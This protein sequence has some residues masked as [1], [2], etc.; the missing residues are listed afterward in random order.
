MPR[1]KKAATQRKTRKREVLTRVTGMHDLLPED[2]VWWNQTLDLIKKYASVY[3]FQD[4]ST[5]VLEKTTLF[6]RGIGK[7]TDIVSKE[8]FSFQDKGGDNLTLRPEWTASVA[9]AYVENGMRTWPQPVKLFSVGPLFRRERPQA[10]RYRQF[11]QANFEIIGNDRP[12]LDAEVIFL[13]WNIL[14]KLGLNNVEIQIN[15]I[16]C[17]ECQPEYSDVLINYF[18]SKKQRLCSDCKRRLKRNPHRILD[19]K[20]ESCQAIA[21]DAPQTVDY[22]CEDCHNHFK[23]VLEYLDEVEVFYNLNPSLVRGLDYY[24]RTTFEFVTKDEETGKTSIALG[25][26]GRYDGLIEQ[27]GGEETGAV[28]IALGLERIIEEVKKQNIAPRKA[29]APDVYLV[30]LGELAKKRGLK[31]F[32]DMVDNNIKVKAIFSKDSIKSQL[33]QADKLR[34]KLSLILGQKEALEDSILIR[35]MESGIQEVAPLKNLAEE[36]KKRLKSNG[37]TKKKK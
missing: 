23:D 17:P 22:L 25:G 4:L 3:S 13:S 33:R 27:L 32:Q 35:D 20:K 28:G 18:S 16:G 1:K 24:T 6:T 15:S 37:V 8:M 14:K 7:S 9:R 34:A 29:K 2:F 26:G 11:H 30:Q 12:V 21:A 31:V 19:C 5:P 10:G 36:V